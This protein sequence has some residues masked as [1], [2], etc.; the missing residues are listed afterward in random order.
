[1]LSLKIGEKI[2]TESEFNVG[3]SERVQN[4]VLLVTK[5]LKWHDL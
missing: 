3:Q 2:K 1:M 4:N 5:K